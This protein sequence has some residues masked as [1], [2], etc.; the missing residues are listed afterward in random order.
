MARGIHYYVDVPRGQRR[1]RELIVYIADKC[2]DDPNFGATKLNKILY[3]SDFRA[4]ERFGMP[5]TGM[6]YFKLPAGPAPKAL[7]PV[8]RELEEEGA[9]RNAPP[10]NEQFAQRRLIAK[11]KAYMDDFT[12]DEIELVDEVIH[13]LWNKTATAVSNESHGV[14]WR[15]RNLRDEIPYEAVFL[16]DTPATPD[17]ISDMKDLNERYGWGLRV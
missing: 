9:V 1:F 14:A 3:H 11:R 2:Q 4:F 17:D 8:V 5:L 16:A 13:E 12:R 7:V 6:R 10:Q 15:A